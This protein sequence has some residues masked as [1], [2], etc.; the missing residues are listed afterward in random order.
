MLGGSKKP[1]PYPYPCGS[2]LASVLHIHFTVTPS[3]KVI[4]LTMIYTVLSVR[5]KEGL[6]DR[7]KVQKADGKI[8]TKKKYI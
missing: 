5:L 4:Q 1:Y 2:F 7:G 3:G 8:N 6:I